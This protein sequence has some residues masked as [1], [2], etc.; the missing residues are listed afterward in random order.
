M[1]SEKKKCWN[2]ISKC[3]VDM[4]G[5]GRTNFQCFLEPRFFLVNN[6]CNKCFQISYNCFQ[7]PIKKAPNI[8]SDKPLKINICYQRVSRKCECTIWKGRLFF[9]DISEF[10][11][12]IIKLPLIL[13]PSWGCGWMS[14]T[15]GRGRQCSPGVSVAS[16]SWG[17]Q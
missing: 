1:N 3:V 14:R 7:I 10:L 8:L 12:M 16:K 2:S 11:I 13:Y 4:M 6:N 15:G 5:S 17:Y 9:T